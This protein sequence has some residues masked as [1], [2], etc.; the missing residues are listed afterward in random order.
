MWCCKKKT[1][2]DEVEQIPVLLERK[3]SQLAETT[4]PKCVN[5]SPTLTEREFELTLINIDK[6]S[7]LSPVQYTRSCRA[8]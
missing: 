8:L 4:P 6:M 3:K 2:E 7:S 1:D 5:V